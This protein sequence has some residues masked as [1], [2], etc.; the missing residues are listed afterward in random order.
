MSS[1]TISQNK[2]TI[3]KNVCMY[4]TWQRCFFNTSLLLISI[5][6]YPRWIKS[7]IELISWN[8]RCISNLKLSVHASAR[9]DLKTRFK[10]IG[11]YHIVIRI[12]LLPRAAVIILSLCL[13]NLDNAL[14]SGFFK[15]IHMVVRRGYHT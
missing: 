1:T 2:C 4:Q 8:S 6:F 12:M 15:R 9:N 5:F 14:L 7:N 10:T 3:N 11:K 13:Q